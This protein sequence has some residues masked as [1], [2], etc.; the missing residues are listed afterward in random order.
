MIE[1]ITIRNLGVIAQ[2][3]LDLRAGMTA[4][5]GETGAGKTMALTSLHLL[6]GGKADISKIR[7]GAE[8][9]FVEGIFSVAPDSPAIEIVEKA[10]GEVEKTAEQAVI[11]TAR[12][13]L[14]TGRSRAYAGGVSVPATLLA[15][16]AAELFTVHGQS[17]QMRLVKSSAHLFALDTYAGLKSK[18]VWQQYMQAWEEY[19]RLQQELKTAQTA[20]NDIGSEKIALTA[21]LER[22]EK[23][24]PQVGEDEAL[25]QEAMRLQNTEVLRS[26]L[27]NTRL[28][29]D[30]NTGQLGALELL[31]KA[32]SELEYTG[33]TEIGKMAA[34][35]RNTSE[36]AAEILNQTGE[37]LES[38]QADPQHLD[39][40]YAR[41]AE[42]RDLQQELSMNIPEILAK[43]SKAEQ[44]LAS[45]ADPQA[46]LDELT[47]R[48]NSQQELVE[49]Y[50]QEISEI[51]QRQAQLLSKAVTA[52][53]QELAMKDARLEI[54]VQPVHPNSTGCDSVEFLL[55]PHK[56]ATPGPLSQIASGGELS[57]IMLA[58]EVVLA[59]AQEI[60]DH[61][62]IFD[63][64]DAG[65][66]GKA[67]LAVGKRLAQ[68]A[69]KSQVLVVTHLPQ[70]ASWAGC[71]IVVEKINPRAGITEVREVKGEAREKELAR[72]LSGHSDSTAARIHAAELLKDAGTE[73]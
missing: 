8:E 23:V 6:L 13:L 47:T 40:I 67:A 72:M 26:S 2:A 38:L 41:R 7:T 25:K 55:M 73:V 52:E 10:G 5:T 60:I 11:I 44:R 9:A 31:D 50:G 70:V 29:L 43:K 35:L 1:E 14:R 65:I 61:T 36:S 33:D 59:G 51:R 3:H 19:L 48:T 4:I 27:N 45:L 69:E 34:A 18:P 12:K 71:Q 58:L 39:E 20:S 24:A 54:A 68:L 28:L 57:R 15:E 49:K 53:L 63:E 42:L 21:L 56:G 46:Y 17:D 16:L 30:G 66:G 37:I 22:I 32:A 64:I 62:F